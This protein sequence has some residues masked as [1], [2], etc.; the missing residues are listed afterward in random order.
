MSRSWR[1]TCA[2]KW[3]FKLLQLFIIFFVGSFV[4]SRWTSLEFLRHLVGL[5]WQCAGKKSSIPRQR[6]AD[7]GSLVSENIRK[8]E[9]PELDQGKIQPEPL[10]SSPKRPWSADVCCRWSPP[11][12]IPMRTNGNRDVDPVPSRAPRSVWFRQDGHLFP[13]PWRRGGRSCSYGFFEVFWV[14]RHGHVS[15]CIWMILDGWFE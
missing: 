8:T 11:E 5:F 10:I 15:G 7:A 13:S 12:T 4:V 3:W 9:R 6:H 2:K 14:G 1:S